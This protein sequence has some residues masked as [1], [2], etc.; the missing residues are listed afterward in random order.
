MFDI[1]ILHKNGSVC[2]LKKWSFCP[3]RR[4]NSPK[5]QGTRG[6]IRRSRGKDKNPPPPAGD[7]KGK[8]QGVRRKE[9]GKISRNI[10]T[11]LVI[12]VLQGFTFFIIDIY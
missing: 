9:H 4:L 8:G 5:E 10:L 1:K 12:I 6:E 7:K 11:Y 2:F 3:F